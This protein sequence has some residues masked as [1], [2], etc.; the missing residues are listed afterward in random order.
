MTD[1]ELISAPVG[2][3]FC[4]ASLP[5]FTFRRSSHA[6]DR[7]RR[8]GYSFN[9][10]T[11]RR[12]LPL[13][14]LRYVVKWPVV[15]LVRAATA[16]ALSGAK[17]ARQGGPPRV[18][19]FASIFALSLGRNV[20]PKSYHLFQLWRADRRKKVAL[21]IQD[22]E[23]RWILEAI[24][25]GKDLT[26]IDDKARFA[27]FCAHHGLPTIPILAEFGPGK[28]ES[29]AGADRHL[30]RHDLFV[31][32]S[33]ATAYA[34]A[35]AE[36]WRYTAPL[37]RWSRGDELLSE[38]ALLE[39]LRQLGARTRIVLQ[40]RVRNHPDVEDLSLGA[41]CSLRV[42]T[43]RLPGRAA[44][45]FRSCLR[46]P[47]GGQEVDHPVRGGIAAPVLAGAVLG[48]GAANV[49]GPPFVVH[50]ATGAR[51]EGRTVPHFT[52]AVRLALQAHDRV[53]IASAIGWDIA[54]TPDGP[55]FLE[56]NSGWGMDVMQ[57]SFGEPLGD[58]SLIGDLQILMDA[59][60]VALGQ[61][62]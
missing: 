59:N 31:K 9:E 45:H 5:W 7:L 58:T 37:D 52:E 15:S 24:H 51:I 8:D 30:S 23:A 32:Q 48:P 35:G 43:V 29:W 49:V 34:G 53:G 14:T 46:M 6:I 13:R 39:H 25:C 55:V 18:R 33:A 56:G 42:V 44:T 38:E 28:A 20:T 4:P 2:R 50:P 47:A 27:G 62:R 3:Y 22:F 17:V 1:P 11:S 21:Y 36:C 10:R 54:I 19:Q 41:L 12:L 60:R 40:P 16:V 57:T 26:I 61:T